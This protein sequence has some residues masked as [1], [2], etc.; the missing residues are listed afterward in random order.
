[1]HPY[2][3]WNTYEIEFQGS[4]WD[5]TG[6]KTKDAVM[7]RVA[8]NGKLVQLNVDL[9]PPGGFTQ[10]GIADAPGPQPLGLQD[11]LDLVQFRNIWATIPK[12]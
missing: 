11:H 3:T 4:V 9:N 12:Y 1:V 10:A 8:L 2:L 6:K 7:V 5:T